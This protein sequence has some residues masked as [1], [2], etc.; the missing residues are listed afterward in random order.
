M[1]EFNAKPPLIS[2]SNSLTVAHSPQ[3]Q[4]PLPS[5]ESMSYTVANAASP[6]LEQEQKPS[7]PLS[8]TTIKVVNSV[9]RA[10]VN[11]AAVMRDTYEDV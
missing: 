5:S 9:L 6:S 8:A 3:P 11:E 10:K 7:G 1:P 2:E 4:E